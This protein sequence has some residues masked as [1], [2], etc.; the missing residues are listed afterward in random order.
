MASAATGSAIDGN[1]PRLTPTLAITGATLTKVTQHGS[2]F[3]FDIHFAVN[4]TKADVSNQYPFEM[5]CDMWEQDSDDDDLVSRGPHYDLPAENSTYT[6]HR[7]NI[8]S[9]S[10]NTELGGEEVYAR[11]FARN[12]ETGQQ[13]WSYTPRILLAPN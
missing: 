9:S 3:N 12:K 13:P 4:F 7:D 5:W 11:C 1:A 6:L 8:S 10:L 2:L